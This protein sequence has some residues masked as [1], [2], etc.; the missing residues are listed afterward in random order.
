[1]WGG[2]FTSARL[3]GSELEPTV[4]A[5]LR[6]LLASLVLLLVLYLKEGFPRPSK[7]QW[8]LLL[9][10]GVTGIASYNLFFFYG[11]VH[12]EATRG[13]L[14]TSINPLITAV[15][16]SLLFKE[17]FTLIRIIGFILCVIG[18]VLIISRGDV[19]ALLKQGMS[20]GDMAFIGCASSWAIFT[21]IGR[22]VS[23]NLS[24]LAVITYASTLGTII[25][26]FFVLNADLVSSIKHMNLNTGLNLI[27]LSLFATVVG[28][29]WFQ[30]GIRVLGAAKAA[31]F[32]YF[33]PVSAVFWA[34]LILDEKITAIL[35]VGA[36]MV[37]TG[38]F[39]VNKNEA[40]D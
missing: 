18:A 2:T 22:F 38:I 34:Y 15:G 37:I 35:V 6:F 28:F 4:S 20:L 16:A 32:I 7:K 40:T 11:L 39:L 14:I 3:L 17:R 26:F 27:F 30:D 24:S 29:V 33:M 10:M 13:S 31:V 23:N 12:S 25:L 21:L 8:L 9:G 1:M 36:F 5:F 19:G